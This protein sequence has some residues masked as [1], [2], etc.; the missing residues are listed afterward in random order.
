MAC[1]EAG[2]DTVVEKVRSGHPTLSVSESVVGVARRA[3]G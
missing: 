2:P 3:A 1:Q